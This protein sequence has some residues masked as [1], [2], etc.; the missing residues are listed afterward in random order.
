MDTVYSAIFFLTSFITI[1]T[2][3]GI[4][5]ILGSET[6]QFFSKVSIIEFF[7]STRWEPLLEPKH[8][9]VLPLVIGTMMIV[10]GSSLISIPIGLITAI[11]I[12]E[13]ACT[14][15]RG[16]NVMTH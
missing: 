1:L 3:I 6:I 15:W 4:I 7:T 5:I 9:G 2:T 13:Y 8:F 14:Q 10:I 11:F 16:R 12:S